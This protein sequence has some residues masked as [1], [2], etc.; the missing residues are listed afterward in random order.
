MN[1]GSTYAL[2]GKI[3]T[4]A[5]S[6][7]MAQIAPKSAHTM[8]DVEFN[9]N[10]I[11]SYMDKAAAGFPGYDLFMCPECGFQAC[12]ESRPARIR[13]LRKTIRNLQK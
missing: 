2:N 12:P 3:E 13:K 11:L 8:E 9:T 1:I 4:E 7:V 10:Q 6:V 5:M